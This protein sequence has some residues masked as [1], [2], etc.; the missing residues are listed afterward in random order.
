MTWS[1]LLKSLLLM[2][3]PLAWVGVLVAE[4]EQLYPDPINVN[5]PP[6]ASDKSVKYDYDIVYV[7]AQRDGDKIHKRYYTDIA[8]PVTME[9]G[10]DLMLLHPDGS[11]ELLVAG[12]EEGAITDPVVSFDGQWVFYTHIH[13][14]KNSG[15]WQPPRKGPT[16]SRSREDATRTC[17]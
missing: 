12:G 7:R 11:E 15:P 13:T 16:S 9:P 2:D 1:R 5:V 4:E 14:L 17:N 10:A 6:I 3:L 8:T